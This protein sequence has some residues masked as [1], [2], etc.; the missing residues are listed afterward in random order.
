VREDHAVQWSLVVPVKRLALAK[1]RLDLPAGDRADLALAMAL[2]VVA[3]GVGCLSVARV[4][5][6]SDDER[7]R[8]SIAALG[9]ELVRDEPD[10]GLNPA[11]AHGVATARRRAPDDGVCIVSSDIPTTTADE[12]VAVLAAAA[13]HVRS[14]VG[15]AAGTGT[16]LLAA[17]ACAE[18]SP[19]FGSQSG[20]AHADAGYVRLAVEAV[21]ISRD[22]D[23]LD[24]LRAVLA[25]APEAAAPRTRA[26]ARRLALLPD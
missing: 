16:T 18:L 23:T 9:V 14:F 10:A 22:V 7:A 1:T 2:D 15:D 13:Q 24:D 25:G 5:V 11:L 3:A 6:V 21:G 26:V 12:L 20:S 8:T 17:R 4:I 19:Q